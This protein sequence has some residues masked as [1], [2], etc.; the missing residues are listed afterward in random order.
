MVTIRTASKL[1]FGCLK[2]RSAAAFTTLHFTSLHIPANYAGKVDGKRKRSGAHDLKV[3]VASS[4]KLE[5]ITIWAGTRVAERINSKRH[6]V[7]YVTQC[8]KRSKTAEIMN[9][10]VVKA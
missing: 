9:G 10:H 2:A 5:S 7:T 3:A 6:S 8:N 1:I 4:S